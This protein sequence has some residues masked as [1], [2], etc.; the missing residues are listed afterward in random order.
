MRSFIIQSPES[1]GTRDRELC[2]LPLVCQSHAIHYRGSA[3]LGSR[4][5]P[6]LLAPARLL[7][8]PGGGFGSKGDPFVA[9]SSATVPRPEQSYYELLG[10]DIT[11][12][13]PEITR[14]YRELMKAA[15]PTGSLRPSAERSEALCKNINLAYA[16]LKDR[17]SGGSTTTPSAPSR[18]CRRS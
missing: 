1:T 4:A 13:T 3:A 17:S 16:T 9:F 6:P 12:T 5:P 8:G 7:D 10:I 11:A 18:C 2:R 14:A 15:T